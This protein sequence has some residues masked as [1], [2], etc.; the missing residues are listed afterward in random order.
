MPIR[1][2]Q[3]RDLAANWTANNPVLADG[4]IGLEKDT[5]LY[6]IGN[7]ST[8]WNSL[9]YA[10]FQPT[11]PVLNLVDQAD[12]PSTPSS[13]L[14]L[15]T[16]RRGGRRLAFMQG[17]SGLDT[18]LQPAFFANGV[19]II[20]PSATTAFSLFGVV[21][22]TAVGTVSHPA[23]STTVNLKDGV[24]RAIVT[25][26]ATANSASELRVAAF[27]C[28]RGDAPGFGGFY[29]RTRWGMNTAVALQRT[30]VGLFAVTT[31]LATTQSPSALTNC[32]LL[33]NDSGDTN[34]QVM[35]NDGSGTCT[36]ID[37]GAEFPANSTTAIYDFD[38]FAAPNS[39]SIGWRVTN[40]AT[41]AVASGTITT[42]LPA[43]TVLLAWHAYANN[44]GTAAAV[45][46]DF[47]RFYLETDF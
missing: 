9:S 32:I 42:D 16:M 25:S 40:M 29:V 22:P 20:A 45:V 28:Y 19:Q 14:Q 34:M 39:N 8:A 1:M 46:L 13:G 43:S 31:A 21:A 11:V 23:I 33:G 2:Q 10:Q 4:E 12:K 30:A 7:G 5:L 15:F 38:L 18:P 41:G 17:P 37:L 36:K 44:G 27:S 6:K 26:T 35:H 3:R 47:Y 24:R